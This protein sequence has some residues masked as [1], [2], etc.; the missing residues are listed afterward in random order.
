M[1]GL[2]IYPRDL[3]LKF[4]TT[5]NKHTLICDMTSFGCRIGT[6]C[7]NF[8]LRHLYSLASGYFR[9]IED[10]LR[11]LAIAISLISLASPA[12]LMAA[13]SQPLTESVF[14]EIIQEVNVISAQ[15]K[16]VTPAR[17]K[18]LFKAPDLVRTGQSSRVELTAKDQTITRIGSNTTFTFAS[19]GRDIQLKKGSVLFHS[20][21][22]AGGGAIKNGGSSAAVLGTTEIGTILQDGRFKVI[23]LEGRVKVILKTGVF[24]LLN[25]GQM[26]IVSADGKSLGEVT[27]FNLG[28]LV[29][30]LHLVVGFSKPLS[31]MPLIEAAIQWQNQEIITGRLTNLMTM[32]LVSIGLDTKYHVLEFLPIFSFNPLDEYNPLDFPR[33]DILYQERTYWRIPIYL[34]TQVN[35]RPTTDNNLRFRN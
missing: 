9:S 13:D 18:E 28:D 24:V 4:A 10:H 5:N 32:E 7:D 31:S 25:P 27:N 19:N 16:S 11:C 30:R 22:G 15:S 12:M 6:L 23:N 35:P 34:P 14:T 33:G 21:A 3:Q 8:S 17:Q 20:P 29:A 1:R 2:R 26:V